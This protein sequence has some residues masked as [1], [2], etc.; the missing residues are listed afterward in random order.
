MKVALSKCLQEQT[1]EANER[2][3]LAKKKLLYQLKSISIL[4]FLSECH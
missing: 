1:P 3:Q 2:Y 4:I